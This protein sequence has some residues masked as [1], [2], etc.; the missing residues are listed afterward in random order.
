MYF[1]SSGVKGLIGSTAVLEFTMQELLYHFQ[2]I[3]I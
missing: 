1:L 3:F 2:A